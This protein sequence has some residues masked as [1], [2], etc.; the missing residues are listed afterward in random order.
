MA[1]APRPIRAPRTGAV[2]TASSANT[3]IIDTNAS[4]VLFESTKSEYGYAAQAK[5]SAPPRRVPSR[6]GRNRRPRRNS[7]TRVSR[8]HAI[9]AAWAAGTSSHFPLHPITCSNGR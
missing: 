4:F 8:S 5:A 3:T 9:A 1:A 7:P 2:L 6:P